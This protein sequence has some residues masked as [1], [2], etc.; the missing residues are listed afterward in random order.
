MEGLED[1]TNFF[2]LNTSSGLDNDD[3]VTHQETVDEALL[4][5]MKKLNFRARD[6]A[7]VFKH[8]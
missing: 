5:I 8:R 3:N 1:I 6:R 7:A 2:S 4:Q